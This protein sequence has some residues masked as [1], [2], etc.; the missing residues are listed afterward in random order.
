MKNK[1]MLFKVLSILL[2]LC[3][4]G[5]YVPL[6]GIE[7]SAATKNDLTFDISSS[8][9]VTATLSKDSSGYKLTISGNGSME[10][11]DSAESVP[12]FKYRADIN[13]V[14]IQNGVTN[15]GAYALKCCN[16]SSFSIPDSVTSVGWEAVSYCHNMTD[17]TIGSGLTSVNSSAFSGNKSLRSL[18]VS[19]S[20]PTFYTSGN[21]LITRDSQKMVLGCS[22]SNIPSN[23]KII[24]ANA[25][26]NQY[27][28]GSMTIPEGVTLIEHYAFRYCW[29]LSNIVIPASVVEIQDGAF[30]GCYDLS[31][32]KFASN[33]KL[34]TI[35]NNVFQFCDKLGSLKLPSGVEN[36]GE[37]NYT[38]SLQEIVA[39]LGSIQLGPYALKGA[40]IPIPYIGDVSLIEVEAGVSLNIADKLQ[41]IAEEDGSI[42]V[43]IGFDQKGAAN[44][45]ASANSTAYWSKSYQE[46]KSIYEEFSGKKVHDTRLWNRFSSLRGKLK[47][48]DASMGINVSCA[49]AGYAEFKVNNGKYEYYDG[50]IIASFDAGV[51]FKHY[52]MSLVYVFLGFSGGVDGSLTFTKED[53]KV[54]PQI[55]V[56]PEFVVSVGGGIGGSIDT[57][58]GKAEAYGQ[59]EAIGTLAAIISTTDLSCPF[60]VGVSLDVKWELAL[61][62]RKNSDRVPVASTELYPDFGS[63]W[64]I[65]SLLSSENDT[66]ILEEYQKMLESIEPMERS[67]L[68]TTFSLRNANLS[69]YSGLDFRKNN[70]YPYNNVK[71]VK[72]NNDN[73]LLVWLDDTGEKTIENRCSV[74]YSYYN[75]QNWT[76]PTA[77]YEDGTMMD[78]PFVY[79][80]GTLAYIVWQKANQ[81][82]ESDVELSDSLSHYDLYMTVFDSKTQSLTEPIQLNN[83]ENS[84]FE[85]YPVIYGSN[86]ISTIAWVENSDNNILQMS[87]NN[88]LHIAKVDDAGNITLQTELINTTALIGNVI[89]CETGAYYALIDGEARS[90]YYYSFEQQTTSLVSSNITCFDY[91]E[92]ILF[93][94]T[95]SNFYSYDGETTICYDNMNGINSFTVAGNNKQFSLFTVTL[96]PDFTKTVYHSTLNMNIAESEWSNF[97]VYVDEGTYIRNLSPVVLNDGTTLVALNYILENSDGSET[98]TIAVTGCTNEIDIA[99]NYVDFD[100]T[101]LKNNMLNL[102]FGVQNNSSVEF[103]A[104]ELIIMSGDQIIK[105]EQLID[106]LMPFGTSILKYSYMLPENYGGEVYTFKILPTGHEDLNE[107]NN[108]AQTP[109]TCVIHDFSAGWIVDVAPTEDTMGIASHHCANC[110][111]IFDETEIPLLKF[112]GASVVLQDN[113]AINYKVNAGLFESEFKNPYVKFVIDSKEVIVRDYTVADGKYVFKFA[114]IAP[115]KLNDTVSATLYAEIDGL[116]FQ[117]E[118]REYSVATYCYNMLE[119]CTGDEY[120]SLRRLLVDLLDYGAQ[121]QI[122]MNYRTDALV[123]SALTEEQKR[124]GTADIRSY[125]SVQNIAYKDIENSTVEWK[126][127]GLR[128]EDSVAMRFKI[129][130][131]SIENLVVQVR[132][133]HGNSWDI[134]SEQFKETTDGYY[135]YFDQFNA[136][137]MSEAVYLTIYRDNVAVSD[138]ISY[139]IESYAYAKRN[140][141]NMALVD[142]VQA[143]MQYG[144]SAYAYA[145]PNESDGNVD[146]G[147]SGDGIYDGYWTPW[148]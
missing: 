86:G 54:N 15:I 126:G 75:G 92:G 137:Q 85:F 69:N 18:N 59:I 127:G 1:F 51:Q 105:Q 70:S 41:I 132:D 84:T 28:M 101:N 77:I 52:P 29:G 45:Q 97:E 115:H 73:M 96:N 135:V 25:F 6:L 146:Y 26:S 83:Q 13:Q 74:L 56:N 5:G 102:E 110:G 145:N 19:S 93:Y 33:S 57:I 122:Y 111:L 12:W 136:G 112:S 61:L 22:T 4:I 11:F 66:T 114:D 119:K 36:I 120:L 55:S 147:E 17:L 65:M 21:C 108:V 116:E 141:S 35:G 23:V 64:A 47:T 88:S 53:D 39:A 37:G 107:G 49:L 131:D 68:Q 62:G 46:V 144:D 3:T 27:E 87:G 71:L 125:R 42:K 81:I 128:L 140:D 38:S 10:S 134:P 20:N 142:L 58:F 8:G 100:D 113:L 143:M 89:L 124:W 9:T 50:G 123:N 79:S 67:Y 148:V 40:K 90:L 72:F 117:G 95:D 60:S 7:A 80:D 76:E 44:V 2:V 118:T 99:L 91:A 43:L 104:F 103:D 30:S 129:S 133:A 31:N 94:T 32:V 24:G 82:F 121:S 16:F 14:I 130:T 48:F 63:P 98:S 138:T 106:K 139:S 34:K 78:R 109:F